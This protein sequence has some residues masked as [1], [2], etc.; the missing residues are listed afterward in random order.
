MGLPAAVE[1]SR[2]VG[3]NHGVPGFGRHLVHVAEAGDSPALL[4]RM[5][6]PPTGIPAVFIIEQTWRI[7]ATSQTVPQPNVGLRFSAWKTAVSHPRTG[8]VLLS[9]AGPTATSVCNSCYY[10][11]V[12]SPRQAGSAD[13]CYYV[14]TSR[15]IETRRRE[16]RSSPVILSNL[17]G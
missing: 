4:I 5:S 3:L 11:M 7:I 6:I 13:C 8:V 1:D 16:L 2:E 14:V 9:F 12:I 10:H 17:G 15:G